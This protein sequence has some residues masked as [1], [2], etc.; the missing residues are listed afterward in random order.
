MFHYT[1]GHYLKIPTEE[2][3]SVGASTLLAAARRKPPEQSMMFS[4]SSSLT[5]VFKDI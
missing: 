2:R 3:Y 1:S 5:G 4:G